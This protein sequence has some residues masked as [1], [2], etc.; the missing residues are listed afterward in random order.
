MATAVATRGAGLLQNKGV[1]FIGGGWAGFIA[2][3]LI[4]SENRQW[5]IEKFGENG[6]ARYIQV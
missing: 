6:E 5:I 4:L 3:N 2:E 1:L